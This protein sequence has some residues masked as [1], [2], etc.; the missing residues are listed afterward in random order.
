MH[1]DIAGRVSA[2]V[3]GHP[4]KVLFFMVVMTALAGWRTSKLDLNTDQIELLP[5]DLPSVVATKD[6]IKLMGGVTYVIVPLKSADLDFTKRVSDELCAKL[7]EV[8][9][10]RYC[11]NKQEVQFLKDRLALFVAPEDLKEGAKRIRKKIRTTLAKNN[12]FYISLREV[13]DEPLVLDDLIDKYRRVDK[14]DVTDPYN[15]D[16][17]GEM[18]M[19]V[20]KPFH[21]VTELKKTRELLARLE[22]VILAT[23]IGNFFDDPFLN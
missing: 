4:R 10:V 17:A 20:I 5:E 12:P 15:V 7:G 2:L 1:F 14:K 23:L 18:L 9:G 3:I 6:M 16:L 22:Q 8:E 13:K 19:L 11:R 21:H